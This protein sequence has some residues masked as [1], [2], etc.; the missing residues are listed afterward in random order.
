[1]MLSSR[2]IAELRDVLGDDGVIEKYEQL[3]T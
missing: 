3:R 2:V 1:M